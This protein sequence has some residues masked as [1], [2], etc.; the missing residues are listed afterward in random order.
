MHTLEGTLVPSGL[1]T[2]CQEQLKDKGG[3]GEVVSLPAFFFS[4]HQG[5]SLQPSAMAIGPNWPMTG[6]YKKCYWNA[7]MSNSLHIVYGSFF[8]IPQS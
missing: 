4:F 2:R 5:S 7:T 8:T 1:I 3:K 6:F